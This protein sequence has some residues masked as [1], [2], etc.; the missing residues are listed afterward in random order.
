MSNRVRNLGVS[1]VSL[2]V[3]EGLYEMAVV[4]PVVVQ[5]RFY[6]ITNYDV[7]I[8]GFGE[9]KE[10]VRQAYWIL[11]KNAELLACDPG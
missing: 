11:K 2:L 6:L 5:N 4:E 10:I 9:E 7:G 8:R 1:N 3:L